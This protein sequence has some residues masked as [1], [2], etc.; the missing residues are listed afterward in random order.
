M[1]SVQPSGGS[2]LEGK[3]EQA[4]DGG[5][6]P[7]VGRY[8]LDLA[9]GEWAW[10][11]EVY[12]MHGFE[13]GEIVPTTPL[14]LSHKH[15]DDRGRV[16]G[17]LRRAAETGQTFSS[18]HRIRDAHGSTRTLAVTGQGRRD[19]ATGRVTEL[20]G[21][22]IDVTDSHRAAAQRDATA[23]IKASAEHRAVIE[24]A[25]GMLMAVYGVEELEA[26]EL[27]REA[28]NRTNIAVR[29]LADRLVELIAGPDVTVFPTREAIDAFLK[30]PEVPVDS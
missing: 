7:P 5:T 29:D 8:R 16:D 12:L 18:V 6:R 4:L 14:M 27:L 15:P 28:S 13:P 10:S 1:T 30:D 17:V 19:P 25:K 3:V 26:F 21:Y 11:D 22:F 20:I 9:T 2:P 24:Q 23:S